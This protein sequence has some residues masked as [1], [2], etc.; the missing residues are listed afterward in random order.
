MDT[1]VAIFVWIM[2]GLVVGAIAR[3]VYPGRQPMGWA[4]TIA[5]GIAGSLVGGAISWA[6]SGTPNR[7]L[8]EGSGWILSIIGALIV[9]WAVTFMNQKSR[10]P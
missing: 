7:P 8:L 10:T 1:I 5:L 4:S 2:F 3:F 6:V 9:V